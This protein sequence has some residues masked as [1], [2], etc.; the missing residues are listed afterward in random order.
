MGQST[1]LRQPTLRQ[2]EPAVP[3]GPQKYPEVRAPG[4]LTCTDHFP[5]P[6]DGGSDGSLHSGSVSPGTPFAH[7]GSS[8][9]ACAGAV[10]QGRCHSAR[11]NWRIAA[12]MGEEA[13]G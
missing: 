4:T 6:A 11:P 10:D 1:D 12:W 9:W 2:R 3:A 7:N 5:L 8:P 13:G